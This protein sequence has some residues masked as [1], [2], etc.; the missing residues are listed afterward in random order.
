LRVIYADSTSSGW[1]VSAIPD[2]GAAALSALYELDGASYTVNQTS[3]STSTPDGHIHW[4][5]DVGATFA[6]SEDKPFTLTEQAP[7]GTPFR[8]YYKAS[9][10]P[11]ANGFNWNVYVCIYP[12]DPGM[13]AYRFDCINP[14]GSAITLNNGSGDAM[15]VALLAGLQQTDGTWIPSNGGY[16]VVGGTNTVGWPATA[17][18]ADPDYVYITPVAGKGVS[19]G[20]M[21]VR[22]KPWTTISPAWTTPSLV[23]LQNTARLKLKV[24]GGLASFPGSTTS[25]VYL[26]NA[27]RGGDCGG[28]SCAWHTHHECG[29]LHHL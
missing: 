20:Q 21:T 28:L 26:L 1:A 13:I 16:G 12:G 15:E 3:L 8:R 10:G 18:G 17:T 22:Q 4:L 9:F 11:D 14:S 6:G 7:V 24:Q 2:Y 5:E 19:I 25:T 29:N 23:Y 27:R